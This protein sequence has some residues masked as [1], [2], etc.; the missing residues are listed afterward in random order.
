[1]LANQSRREFKFLLRPDQGPAVQAAVSRN[2]EVDRDLVDGYRV[3]SEYY[4]TEERTSYWDKKLG[5]ANRRRIRSRVYE[6]VD[7][8][9]PPIAFLEVKHKLDG[10]A[11]K[12]RLQAELHELDSLDTRGLPQSRTPAD[13]PVRNELEDLLSTPAQKP[14]MQIRYHRFAYDSGPEGEIRITFDVDP[15]CRLPEGPSNEEPGDFRLP[16]IDEGASIMEVKTIDRVPYWFRK[17]VGH[18]Q[19]VPCGFSKYARAVELYELPTRSLGRRKAPTG[20]RP[21]HRAT[22]TQ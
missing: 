15:V 14:V 3:L 16:L 22:E 18:F 2:L 8:S 19:L 10:E 13:E 20:A 6:Q 17:L 4:D 5:V 12:R 7:Q 21:G 11:V 1:M 9:L